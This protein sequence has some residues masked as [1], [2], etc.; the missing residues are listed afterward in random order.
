MTSVLPTQR[1]ISAGSIAGAIGAV[2]IAEFLLGV[3]LFSGGA[4]TPVPVL[5]FDASVLIGAVAFTNPSYAF[6]GLVL[7]FLVSI[8]WA[9]GYAYMAER[10]PQLVTRPWISGAAFGLVIYFAM[11]IVLVAAN[12]YHAPKPAEV[13]NGLIAHILFFGI[14]VALIVSRALRAK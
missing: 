13:G 14:P 1:S 4:F 12:A 11:L 2:L 9:I 10:Q 7:H 8:G 5:Q 6:L 3:P